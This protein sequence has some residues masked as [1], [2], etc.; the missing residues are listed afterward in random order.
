MCCLCFYRYSSV[1]CA[2]R[3]P[4]HKLDVSMNN[5]HQ[6]CTNLVLLLL[7]LGVSIVRG[8][9]ELFSDDFTVRVLQ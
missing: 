4:L 8:K 1:S 6:L 3:E 9:V 2:Q 7:I 5:Y